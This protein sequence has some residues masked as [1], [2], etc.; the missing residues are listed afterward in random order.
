MPR[1][2]DQLVEVGGRQ[3]PMQGVSSFIADENKPVYLFKNLVN[4]EPAVTFGRLKKRK[5]YGDIITGQTGL[6]EMLELRD[7]N[8]AR[9]LAIQKGAAL[10]GSAYSGGAYGA[11]AQI[12]TGALDFRYHYPYDAREVVY[13]TPTIYDLRMNTFERVLRAGNG[14]DNAKNIPVEYQYLAAQTR[15]P[16][17]TS[18]AVAAGKYL[19]EQLLHENTLRGVVLTSLNEETCYSTTLGLNLGETVQ[20]FIIA[21]VVPVYDGYQMGF[22][23]R[24]YEV[25]GGYYVN[26]PSAN[27]ASMRI[28]ISIRHEQYDGLP[29]L[30]HLDVYVTDFLST[31]VTAG[32]NQIYP[33]RAAYFLERVSLTEDPDVITAQT[34]TYENANPPTYIEFDTDFEEWETID[35]QYFFIEHGAYRYQLGARTTAGTKAR[36]AISGGAAAL[37]NTTVSA[38]IRGVW[39]DT[40]FTG[41]NEK[42]VEILYDKYYRNQGAEMYERLGLP[43]GDLGLED[44]R[45]KYGCESNRRYFIFGRDDRWGYFSKAGSPDVIPVQNLIKLRHEPTGCLSVGRDVMV[46]S[47]LFT[48]RISVITDTNIDKDESFLDVGC[49]NDESIIQISDDEAAW[50]SYKGPYELQLRQSRFIGQDLSEWWETTLTD[51]EKEACV[52]AYNYRKDQIWFFF[53]TYSDADYPNGIIFV[54]DRHARKMGYDHVW[55]YFKSDH[56]ALS[57]CVNDDGHL[58]TNNAADI[59]DWNHGTPTETVETIIKLLSVTGPERTQRLRTHVKWLFVDGTFG[60]TITA[61]IYLNGSATPVALSFDANYE[62]F[63]RYLA[64]TF[65]V[66]LTSPASLNDVEYKKIQ[67][68]MKAKSF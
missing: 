46:F 52:G 1:R 48:D 60:D 44:V 21:Y 10:Y 51:A 12:D 53:P 19:T 58:L 11:L 56:A 25:A 17:A 68:K 5:G 47:K 45:Y 6:S 24:Y 63:V 16:N 27:N 22:P 40:S 67:F 23:C 61:N 64:E 29:R 55:Y 34:G 33:L 66:E 43:S 28:H 35:F 2:P 7:K 62:A 50:M 36:Y 4:L 38:N 26:V 65:E 41:A 20:S 13:P 3:T 42:S 15:Y 14:L 8:D 9:T 32:S 30:T 59:V 54:Y 18:T 49:T 31:D 37:Q 57:S 39:H